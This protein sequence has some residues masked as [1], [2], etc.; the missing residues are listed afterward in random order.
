MTSFGVPML[1]HELMSLLYAVGLIRGLMGWWVVDLFQHHM[2]MPT[3]L[4]S[5]LIYHETDSLAEIMKRSSNEVE[6]D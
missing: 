3:Y 1:H 6:D 2:V 4:L 5:E